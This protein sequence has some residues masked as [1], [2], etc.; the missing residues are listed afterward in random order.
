[1]LNDGFRAVIE[2]EAPGLVHAMMA[3]SLAVT[4]QAMLSRMTAGIRGKSLIVNLP[5][6]MKGSSENFEVNFLSQNP[7]FLFLL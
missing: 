4:R 5:G 7:G 3:G 1:L 2:R 6:N